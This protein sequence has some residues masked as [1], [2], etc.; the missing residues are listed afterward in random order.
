MTTQPFAASA[1][2]NAACETAAQAQCHCFC[3]GAGHQNDLVVRAADCPD[4]TAFSILTDDLDGAFGE[5]HAH[6]RDV[7]TPTRGSRTVPTQ[8]EIAS[9]RFTVGKGATWLETLLVDEALHSLFINAALQSV[10]LTSSSRL[11][12]RYFIE[13]ITSRAIGIVGSNVFLTN[14]VESHVWCSIVS[15][16]MAGLTPASVSSPPPTNF[17]DICY[18]RKTSGKTPT[19]LAS[20]RAAGLAHLQSEYAGASGITQQSRIDLLQLVGAAT[21]PDLWHH[22]A[23]VRYCLAPAVQSGSWPPPKT[24]SIAINPVFSQLERR[25]RIRGHW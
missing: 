3:H 18:P 19:S 25:W 4:A 8:L 21:C 22:P 13:G 7:T 17:G 9:L 6:D 16:F 15:E 2:H 12:Q 23:A 14:V 11:A 10:A 24:T 1:V 5:F 20:V